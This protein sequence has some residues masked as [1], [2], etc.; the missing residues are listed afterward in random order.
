M[1]YDLHRGLRPVS[2]LFAAAA[3]AVVT[4]VGIFFCPMRHGDRHDTAVL[5]ERKQTFVHA[6]A[7]FFRYPSAPSV[8]DEAPA[9]IH[10]A[11]RST[12]AP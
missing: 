10:I 4:A 3:A 12:A 7:Q 1:V 8:R 6:H 2:A 11:S 9:I 5:I